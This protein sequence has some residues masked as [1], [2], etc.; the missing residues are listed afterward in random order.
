MSRKRKSDQIT[1]KEIITETPPAE[2][3][4]AVAEPFRYGAGGA[5]MKTSGFRCR[6]SGSE[7]PSDSST[8]TY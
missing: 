2:T 1:P 6:Y 3:S 5:A 7:S 8:R 4:T